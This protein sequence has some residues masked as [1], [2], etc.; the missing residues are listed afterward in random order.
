MGVE[1]TD[2]LMFGLDVGPKNF[3][4]DDFEA[5]IEGAPNARFDIVY[6][7]MCGEY[8]IAGKVIARSDQYEG[9]VLKKIDPAALDIDR[10]ALASKL[11]EAFAR[12]ITADDLA[13]VLFSHFH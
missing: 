1:R 6:D 7:G 11:S 4:R 8:C 10:G 3:N 12:T 5:E 2:Y 9:F 13:L